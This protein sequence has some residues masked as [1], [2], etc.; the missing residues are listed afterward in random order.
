MHSSLTYLENEGI[1]LIASSKGMVIVVSF[2][3]SMSLLLG[4]K[5][6]GV[7]NHSVSP[8]FQYSCYLHVHYPR[9]TF[10]SSLLILLP[11]TLYHMDQLVFFHFSIVIWLVHY[12][13]SHLKG[14]FHRNQEKL[15]YED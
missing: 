9:Q 2:K 14:K 12:P 8:P 4:E 5:E 3:A 1:Y 6:W 11:H 7:G 13:H 10:L 15:H